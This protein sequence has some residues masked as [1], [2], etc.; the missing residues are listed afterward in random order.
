MLLGGRRDYPGALVVVEGIDGSG[1]STQLYLLE[2]LARDWRL[3]HSLH[4]VELIAAGEIRD[5]AG[6]AAP[7]ADAGHVFADPRR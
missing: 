1:K 7:L 5:E 6:K 3:S 2:A 4:G